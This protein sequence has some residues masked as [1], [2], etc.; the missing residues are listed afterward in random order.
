MKDISLLLEIAHFIGASHIERDVLFLQSKTKSECPLILPL[1]GEFS[2]GKTSLINALTDS[3]ALETA[4]MPT[5]ATIYEIHFGCEENSA[6]ITHKDGSSTIIN[7]ISSLHND[8]IRDAV[9]VDVYDTSKRVPS[10]I[11]LVDTPGLSSSDPAHKQTLVDFIPHA[12]GILIVSDV[13]QQLT[14]STLDFIKMMELS[15]RRVF[16]VLTKCDTKEKSEIEA[17]ISYIVDNY[18]VQKD[19]IIC[20]SAKNDEL[21][22]FNHLLT[23]IQSEKSQIMLRANEQRANS[24]AS[25]LIEQM[26][27][28]LN[29]GEDD[30]SMEEALQSE[31]KKLRV[32]NKRIDKLYAD[33]Q[34]EINDVTRSAERSFEDTIASKLESMIA[35]R[36]V[37]FDSEASSA[38]N[39][40]SSLIVSALRG[41]IKSIVLNNLSKYQ[42]A[43]DM[44]HLSSLEDIDVSNYSVN[45]LSYDLNLNEMGHQYD[46][47]IATGIK[48]A[49]IAAAA[50]VGAMGAE[51]AETYGVIDA[52]IDGAQEIENLKSKASSGLVES[53]VGLITDNTMGKPQRRRAIHEYMDSY[54][55]PAFKAELQSKTQILFNNISSIIKKDAA[56]A[57]EETKK[58]ISSLREQRLNNH[59]EYLQKVSTIK[60]YKEQL[61]QY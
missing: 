43:E 15:N 27:V 37:N 8:T 4:T 46:G 30:A 13:N 57:I 10:S 45:G 39:N 9:V 19:N 21:S 22:D 51:A 53:M 1:V 24:I 38:I 55:V 11:V 5:T 52:V 33:I 36:G 41:E 34:E 44:I 58:A 54:L 56:C 35:N 7:D 23:T 20:V 29:A 28:V 47:Y 49:A 2:S 17:A 59:S 3:K 50:E 48:V 31:E 18:H 40:T 16:Y 14:R 42:N 60:K 26:N 12:D 25:K 61:K 32:I 6:R